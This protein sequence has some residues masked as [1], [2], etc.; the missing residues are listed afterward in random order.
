MAKR[1]IARQLAIATYCYSRLVEAGGMLPVH[2]M[3]HAVNLS[4]L[5]KGKAVTAKQLGVY[6]RR[7]YRGKIAYR[8]LMVNDN[9]ER[10]RVGCYYLTVHGRRAVGLEEPQGLNIAVANR[11]GEEAEH[12]IAVAR[13]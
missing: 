11:I 6:L 3:V 7:F 2:K 5:G 10:R 4:L 9:G 12:A 13:T 1:S 8:M